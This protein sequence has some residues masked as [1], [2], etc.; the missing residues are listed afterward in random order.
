MAFEIRQVISVDKDKCVNC[1][2]CISV[3]PVRMCNDGSGDYVKVNHKL[4]IGCGRCISACDHGARFGIDDFDQFMLDLSSRKDIVAIV[5]PAVAVTFRGKDLELNTWL[6]SIGV[7][8]V[9]DV[10]FGAELTTK[11]YVEYI[12]TKNPPVVI[13]Q[14]CP[15]LVSFCEMYRPNLLKYLAP[16]DSPMAHTMRMIKEYYPQYK[17]HKIA[18]ISPC[19]AKRREFDEIGLG[20]YNVTMKSLSEYFNS[21]GINLASFSKTPYDNP[22]AE[23]AVTYSTPGG[24]LGTAERFVPGISSVTRKIEGFPGVVEYLVHLNKSLENGE[25]PAFKLI[26]C[27][28]CA[29]GCNG[30]AGTSTSGMTLDEMEGLVTKRKVQRQEEWKT[31]KKNPRAVKKINSTINKYWR[32]GLY[33]R[34]YVDNSHIFKSTIRNPSQQEIN[35][36]FIKMSKFNKSDILNCSA[37]GYKS[38]EQ[39]AVAIYNGLNKPENCHHYNNVQLRKLQETK[40]QEMEQV[41]ASLKDVTLNSLTESDNDVSGIEEVSTRM[42]ESVSNSSSAIE[43]MI[44]NIQS[45]NNVLKNNSGA[46][47]NLTDATKTGKKSIEEITSIIAEIEKNSNGL[48]E[49]S[50]VIQQ[51]SS[52]TNLLAMNAAIEAAHAGEFGKGFSVVADEIRKLAESSGKEAKQISEVLKNVKTLI[53]GVFSKAKEVTSNIDNIVTLSDEVSTQESVVTQSVNEQNEGGQT[54][55]ESLE[56]MKESTQSVTEAVEKLRVSSGAVKDAIVNLNLSF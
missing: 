48:S 31:T 39:M 20:D 33:K 43:E 30:G 13:A 23:R 36:I 14:P 50:N 37:C 15:A 4:C 47:R 12:K 11:T 16:A 41:V 28:G 44:S 35:D 8:A 29:V 24:L 25:K 22:E 9:F 7:K 26:D 5:A 46:M 6:K 38:C 34:V 18:V 55:L 19:Y 40:A 45:I 56:E 52:Q 2:R 49:M 42:V 27:L 1:H 21:K 32:N 51:I 53:D 17:N 54:L 3:C 10:S